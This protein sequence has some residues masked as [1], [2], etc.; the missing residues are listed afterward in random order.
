MVELKMNQTAH[1][2][3]LNDNVILVTGAGAGIGASVAKAYAKQGATIILLDKNI[4]ALEQ[5]YDDIENAGGKMPA[6]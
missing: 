2:N 1:A 3:L 6:I 5:I 4:K